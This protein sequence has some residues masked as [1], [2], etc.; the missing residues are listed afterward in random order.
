MELVQQIA[1]TSA[2]AV[3]HIS[4]ICFGQA[5][6]IGAG[7]ECGNEVFTGLGA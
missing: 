6:Q 4:P 7:G 1:K 5:Q 3:A 2:A